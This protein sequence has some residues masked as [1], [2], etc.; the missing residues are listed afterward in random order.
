MQFELTYP[1]IIPDI[2][3]LVMPD[4]H[5]LVMSNTHPLVMPDT[6]PL[7]MHDTTVGEGKVEISQQSTEQRKSLTS[8][9][10]GL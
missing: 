1:L 9:E 6:Y 7:V 3:P 8:E 5:P 10:V 2:Y 4:T